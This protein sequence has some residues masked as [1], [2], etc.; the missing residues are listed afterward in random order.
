MKEKFALQEARADENSVRKMQS[1]VY[2]KISLSSAERLAD[3]FVKKYSRSAE[4]KLKRFKREGN[5]LSASYA[6]SSKDVCF[7]AFR[8]NL[9]ILSGSH[10]SVCKKVLRQS[11]GFFFEYEGNHIQ[12]SLE[13]IQPDIIK[14]K[15]SIYFLQSP[16]FKATMHPRTNG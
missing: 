9:F 1:E 16:R 6:L 13:E 15:T 12:R 4:K 5:S 10:D 14:R 11:D 2:W 7:K 3:N 8:F